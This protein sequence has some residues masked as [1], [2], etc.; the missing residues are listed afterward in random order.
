M[1]VNLFDALHQGLGNV[2]DLRGQQHGLTVSNLANAD[3]PGYLARQ[4]DFTD[5]LDTAMETGDGLTLRRTRS[6]H[7]GSSGVDGQDYDID[8]RE[9]PAWS[10]DGNSVHA[11]SEMSKLNANQLMY[12]AV[13][14]GVSRRLAILRYAASDGKS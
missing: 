7:V 5:A 10:E 9:A 4:I 6:E 14:N 8:Q 13:A 12:T 11:E 1:S 2:L 3:T